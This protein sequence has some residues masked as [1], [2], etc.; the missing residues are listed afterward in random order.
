[1]DCSP[2]GSSVHGI[3]WARILEWVAMPSS[4]ESSRPLVEPGSPALE[5]DALLSEPPGKCLVKRHETH[6]KNI[7][8]QPLIQ[9]PFRELPVLLDFPPFPFLGEE[10]NW[11]FWEGPCLP[12]SCFIFFFLLARWN[13]CSRNV[14]TDLQHLVTK[15]R[16]ASLGAP[17]KDSL[18]PPS[19]P[20]FSQDPQLSPVL[21]RV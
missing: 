7:S 19:P 13:P 14:G 9:F 12:S 3:L 10:E 1:M 5:A 21:I 18:A 4:R 6:N 15:E 17:E 8:I 11:W 20:A 16:L 2:P